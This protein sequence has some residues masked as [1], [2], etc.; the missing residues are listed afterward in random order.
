M[1][2]D[3]SILTVTELATGL[4][5][6]AAGQY[7]REAAVELL[8]RHWNWLAKPVFT[9]QCVHSVDGTP[10]ALIVSWWRLVEH[11]HADEIQPNDR[12]IALIAAQLGGFPDPLDV[13]ID[14]GDMPP[15]AW[16]MASLQR[17]DVDLVLAAL[18]HAGGTH[19][20]VDHVGEP[21]RGSPAGEWRITNSSARLRL[22]SLHAW[23]EPALPGLAGDA[24]DPES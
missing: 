14:M 19:D 7:P 18:S 21:V 9:Q 13:T 12:A 8:I 4:R 3:P 15:L 23:P 1:S 11:A 2:F 16:L 5:T 10:D 24:P 22:G 17:Q 20:H 6:G